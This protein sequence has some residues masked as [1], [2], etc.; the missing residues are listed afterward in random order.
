MKQLNRDGVPPLDALPQP[1]ALATSDLDDLDDATTVIDARPGREDFMQGHLPGA[2]YAPFGKSFPTVAGSY[3]DPDQPVVLVIE[4]EHVEAATRSLVRV[5][6]DRVEGYATPE[7][8]TDYAE[9]GETLDAIPMTDMEGMQS[10]RGDE[11]TQVVDVRS[12]TEHRA[13]HVPGTLLAPH[14]RL[15][16]QTGD[17]PAGKTLLV[18]CGSGLRASS[19]A[20]LLD[21]RGFDVVHVN[22]AF[23]NWSEA[24]ADEVK[25]GDDDAA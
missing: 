6:L 21:A 3:A 9:A 19:A 10:K 20:S 23:S 2:L 12:M 14:T 13:G 4:E 17:L 8:L 11:N 1:R 18:H 25:K 7:V 15:P 16:E 24:H 22:D 5:G